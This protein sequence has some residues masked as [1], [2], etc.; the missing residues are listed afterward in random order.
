M[1]TI[2]QLRIDPRTPGFFLR[3]DYYDVLAQLRAE[4]PIHEFAPGVKCVSRYDDIREISRDPDRF[5]SG[6]GVLANDPLR[7]GGTIEGSILHMDPPAHNGWRKVL[8][9]DFTNR[10]L[11][12]MEDRVRAITV[13]LLDAIPPGE[14]VDLVEVLT[15][16]LPVLVI[17][18]LLGVPERQRSEFRRWSDAAIVASDGRAAMSPEEV[19]SMMEM[20]TFLGELAE[21]KAADPADD[22]IS[23]LVNAEIDGRRFTAGELVTF[24]LSLVVAGNETTRHLMSGSLIEL[25]ARPDDRAALYADPSRIPGAVE[26]CLRW[27]TP[28]QQFARTVTADTE[29]SGVEVSEG[30]YLV[31]LYASGNR[32]EAAFG[33]TASAFDLAR[34]GTTPNLAFGFGEHFCL[35]AALARMEARVLFEELGRRGAEYEQ[36]GEAV[37]LPSSLVRGPDSAPFVFS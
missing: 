32:D 28:I 9:R 23:L 1:T 22:I 27:V 6:R 8:N 36:A 21:A 20:F 7:E 14:V 26:E 15:A 19:A 35:G 17:C 29:L 18:E 30:D 11:S 37:Y 12:R 24:N 33:P 3:P 31:M 16:P 4:A 10:A 34:E 13:E 25:A 2:D 5:C